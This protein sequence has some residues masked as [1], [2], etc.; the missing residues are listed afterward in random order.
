M[1]SAAM[2]MMLGDI[3]L[4]VKKTTSSSAVATV[5]CTMLAGNVVGAEEHHASPE[6]LASSAPLLLHLP[7]SYSSKIATG[8]NGEPVP[9]RI[10]KGRAMNVNRFPIS[11]S[12]LH[13]FSM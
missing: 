7:P 13:R 1:P 6:V 11:L 12:R 4:A 8:R 5:A 3:S 2:P 9:L 10:F